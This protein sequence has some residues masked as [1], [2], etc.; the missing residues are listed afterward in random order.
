MQ[1]LADVSSQ[2]DYLPTAVDKEAQT[3]SNFAFIFRVII[4]DEKS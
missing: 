2:M 1:I 4:E 3:V